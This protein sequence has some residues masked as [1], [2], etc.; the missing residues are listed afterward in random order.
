[1]PGSHIAYITHTSNMWKQLRKLAIFGGVSVQQKL[2]VRQRGFSDTACIFCRRCSPRQ[3][4]QSWLLRMVPHTEW[5]RQM[6]SLSQAFQGDGELPG[7][8]SPHCF[9]SSCFKTSFWPVHPTFRKNPYSH[10]KVEV[11]KGSWYW[12]NLC[13]NAGSGWGWDHLLIEDYIW[14]Y[15]GTESVPEDWQ[16][17]LIV[18][19]HMQYGW[20][21]TSILGHKINS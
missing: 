5:Q 7:W 8:C 17:Q 12:W 13:G 18:P 15:L 2:R 19:L 11:R 21:R 6:E 14:A 4:H 3:P 10:L 1:M 20:V 9:P 16:S